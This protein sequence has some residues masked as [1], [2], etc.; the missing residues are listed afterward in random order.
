MPFNSTR[1]LAR[2]TL[3]LAAV[4]FSAGRAAAAEPEPN[5]A[6]LTHWQTASRSFQKVASLIVS[7]EF[8]QAQAMLTSDAEELPAPYSGLAKQ[9][10]LRF[11]SAF[12]IPDANESARLDTL[13]DV[14]M[15]LHAY[16]EAARLKAAA[17]PQTGQEDDEED[18]LR[19][20]RLFETGHNQEAIA[21]YER[22]LAD[23]PVST[24]RAFYQ[25]QIDLLRQRPAH[26]TNATFALEFIR[27]HYLSGFENHADTL[28][29]LKELNRVQPYAKD[30]LERVAIA[31]LAIQCLSSLN[32]TA[33]RDAWEDAVLRQFKTDQNACAEICLNRGIRA[34]LKTDYAAA[35]AQFRIVC[36]EYPDSEFY[37]DALYNL[38]STLQDQK[39]YDD[40]VQ[41]FSKLFSSNVDDYKLVPGSSDDYRLYR[42]K[43]AIRIS[44]CYE[45]KKDYVRALDY[46]ELAKNQYKPLSWCHTCQENAQKALDQRISKLQDLVKKAG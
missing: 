34:Y 44:E 7:R 33:G 17:H 39:R 35:L 23:S 46:A 24:W 8:K 41:E 43:A 4:F 11:E 36:Q 21:E 37:G 20:W 19:A 30:N 6:A 2:S 32:D 15:R 14:C 45:S 16:S 10:L 5:Q 31:K 9:I 40:A 12:N 38:G 42:H 22:K 27:E 18:D 25:K 28:C 29:A 1:L 3:L 13:S 26:L